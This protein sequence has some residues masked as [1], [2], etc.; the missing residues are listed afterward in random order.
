MF[1]NGG[2]GNRGRVG[3]RERTS[4]SSSK[5]T[6]LER[7]IF[8]SFRNFI[9]FETS[10]LLWIVSTPRQSSNF[11]N[12]P[13]ILI[14]TI[15][16]NFRI[17]R[18]RIRIP[19]EIWIKS[20]RILSVL[21]FQIQ[22][23]IITIIIVNKNVSWK[24]SFSI[25]IPFAMLN[26]RSLNEREREREGISFIVTIPYSNALLRR[27]SSNFPIIP[28]NLFPEEEGVDTSVENET[29]RP[30]RS[31][32]VRNPPR[33]S[34]NNTWTHRISRPSRGRTNW[35]FHRPPSVFLMR[36]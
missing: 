22:S 21:R 10:P 20:I 1:Y 31:S 30:Y 29:L 34:G 5:S 17:I 28:A 25:D 19:K 15:K 23:S 7:R 13:I 11:T 26:G 2:K 4:Y 9:P 8:S 12:I 24:R 6:K 35:N 14:Y 32:L 36:S 27:R 33:R 3:R 18:Y 16:S